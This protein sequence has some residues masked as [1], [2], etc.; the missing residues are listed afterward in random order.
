MRPEQPLRHEANGALLF[1]T[2]RNC[3]RVERAGCAAVLIDAAA[4]FRAVREAIGNAT[5]SVI[6][7]GWTF[8]P[9]TDLVPEENSSGAPTT[10]GEVLQA[11]A[12]ASP[13]LDLRVLIW[14]MPLPYAARNDF[15]PRRAKWWF[16]DAKVKF[17]VDS[18]EYTGASHH[19]KIVVIDDA[20]AFCGGGDFG[21]ERWDSTAHRDRDSRRRLPSGKLYPP[22]HD[23]MMMVSGS[24][25][26]A[27]GDLARRRWEN[28]TGE[29]VPPPQAAAVNAVWPQ[30]V[31]PELKDVPVAI[32]RTEPATK[33]RPAVR[34]NEALYLDSI[35][36]AKRL[37]F[38]ENQYLT[39][40]EIGAALAARLE[41][42]HGP[43]IAV[44]V[45]QRSPGFLDGL[46]MD[47][48][49]D[50]LIEH[51]RAV[52]RYGRFHIYS[53]A[54]REGH[55]IIVH[56][57]V[58]VID[59]V[60]L[61]IGSCNLANRSMGFD[62]ECDLSVSFSSADVDAAGRAA[63]VRFR[64]SLVGHYLGMPPERIAAA[65]GEHGSLSGAIAALDT[66]MPLR[67]PKLRPRRLG[68]FGK[69]I[70]QYHLGDPE[71]AADAW[72]PWRR[73]RFGDSFKGALTSRKS[74]SSGR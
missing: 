40:P 60:F 20:V 49:R 19:Q 31:V 71:G 2:G 70:A 64:N 69:L 24:A 18:C 36:A 57:K 32:S 34:E 65:M 58:S 45:T 13:N 17:R 6:L 8:H 11:A 54:T 50:R 33:G 14:D 30:H 4:Y 43:E 48:A 23:V 53:P 9:A 56:S 27:L 35:A 16:D 47:A 52:D 63:T 46:C 73:R 25:A 67:L 61:R 12:A 38:L 62:T 51:L 7:V 66:E 22:R 44:I 10:I 68:P 5:R 74:T 59:D 72:R 15:F 29:A 39:A 41:E 21:R 42:P 37:I 55:G 1:E 3:W 28:A 26:A